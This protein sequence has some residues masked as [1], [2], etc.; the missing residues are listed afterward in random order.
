MCATGQLVPAG[1]GPPCG[2]CGHPSELWA[3]VCG[4]AWLFGCRHRERW[5]D[6]RL[7]TA[8]HIR[9]PAAWAEAELARRA[10][11]ARVAK[12]KQFWFED[13]P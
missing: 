3:C 7:L 1:V 9:D 4:Y 10:A 12:K 13:D 11:A 6:R 2:H 5:M 8:A